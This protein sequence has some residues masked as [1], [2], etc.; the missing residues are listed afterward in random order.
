MVFLQGWSPWNQIPT[1]TKGLLYSISQCH[2]YLGYKFLL[3]P[4]WKINFKVRPGLEFW[5][6]QWLSNVAL[7]HLSVS[8]E[9][10]KAEASGNWRW[11]SAW[12]TGR[13]Q[14]EL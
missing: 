6:C 1:D 4:K 14:G 8:G 10:T 11:Y 12:D 7:T 13:S 2:L 9:N 5:F 3:L